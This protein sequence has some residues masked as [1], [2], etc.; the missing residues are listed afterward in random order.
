MSSTFEPIN[1]WL[2]DRHSFRLLLFALLCMVLSSFPLFLIVPAACCL[3]RLLLYFPPASC[4][5]W[6]LF[7][8]S[9]FF[10]T[11]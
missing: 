6:V 2:A 4:N 10:R 5:Q 9:S 3:W 8:V 1:V 11:L 7:M